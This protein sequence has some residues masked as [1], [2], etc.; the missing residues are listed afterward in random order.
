MFNGAATLRTVDATVLGRPGGGTLFCNAKKF[1]TRPTYFHDA[2][3]KRGARTL[4]HLKVWRPVWRGCFLTRS[5]TLLFREQI[6]TGVFDPLPQTLGGRSGSS[7]APA[8][9]KPPLKQQ[10]LFDSASES[11]ATEDDEARIVPI[12]TAKGKK[13]GPSVSARNEPAGGFM[14]IGSHNF[15]P[16]AWGRVTMA[17]SATQPTLTIQNYELGILFVSLPTLPKDYFRGTQS[18]KVPTPLLPAAALARG[19][20][21]SPCFFPRPVSAPSQALPEGR[22]PLVHGG[23]HAA[24][25][26]SALCS[27]FAAV[28]SPL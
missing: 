11:S 6:L 5:L 18:A 25:D 10:K 7:A 12:R 23:P 24:R 17:K 4:M 2:V 27:L 14:Y 19:G 15:T 9:R 8:S 20:C 13:D 3:S 16:S 21:S 22:R 26:M 28:P 1:A